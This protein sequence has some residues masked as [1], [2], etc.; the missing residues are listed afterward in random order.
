MSDS[1]ANIVVAEGSIKIDGIDCGH[2]GDPVAVRYPREYFDVKG[3]RRTKEVAGIILIIALKTKYP[4]GGGA[5]G[6]LIAEKLGLMPP[7]QST[8]QPTTNPDPASAKGA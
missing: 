3:S 8:T 6:K 5:I 7:P 4:H 2:L 1:D